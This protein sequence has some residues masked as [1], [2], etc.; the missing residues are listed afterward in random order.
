M[1]TIYLV[2]LF[3]LLIVVLILL[4]KFQ[5]ELLKKYWKYL[6]GAGAVAFSVVFLVGK[7]KKTEKPDVK[8]DKKKKKLDEGLEK[9][10]AEAEVEIEEAKKEEKKVTDKL[11][12]IKE[13]SDEKERL[14]QL[15]E[16]F[17]ETRR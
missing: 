1:T 9:V 14:K 12:K 10:N 3:S 16:L 7:L 8:G 17:N 4:L 6:A 11:E 15:A 2:A 5:P 13:I